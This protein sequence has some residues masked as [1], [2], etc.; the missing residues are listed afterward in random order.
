MPMR[1]HLAAAIWLAFMILAT[2]LM[3]IGLVGYTIK[4]KA[5]GDGFVEWH[6][7]F[8]DAAAPATPSAPAPSAPVVHITDDPGGSVMVYYKKYAA[9]NAAGAEIHFHGM[10]ASSCTLLFLKE[11]NNLRVCADDGAIFG[12]HKPFQEHDGKVVRTKAAVR[13]TRKLWGAWVQALPDKLRIYLTSVRVPSAAEGDEMN[14]L[15]LI[16]GNLLLPRCAVSEA[17]L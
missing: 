8:Y 15:L 10:C 12:F 7:V 6:K 9:L 5:D 2:S 13:D 16:P 17:S 1:E 4:V 14:T 3:A 11:F